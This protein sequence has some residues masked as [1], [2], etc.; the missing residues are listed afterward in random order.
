MHRRVLRLPNVATTGQ[1][2][3]SCNRLMA[4]E[5]FSGPDVLHQLIEQLDAPHAGDGRVAGVQAAFD[6]LAAQAHVQHE[7]A[8]AFVDRKGEGHGSDLLPVLL[9]PLIHSNDPRSKKA[10]QINDLQ[11]FLYF[12][13]VDGK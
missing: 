8:A 9:P 1:L 10:L 12:G 6:L 5:A 2:G 13:G 3:N 11:G 4:F 7:F